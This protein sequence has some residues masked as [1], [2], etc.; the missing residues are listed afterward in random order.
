MV[1]TESNRLITIITVRPF[2]T[3]L[4]H[5]ASVK[6]YRVIGSKKIFSHLFD[7]AIFAHEYILL[8]TVTFLH[9]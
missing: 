7:E 3:P 6:K 4:R 5:I 9:L 8:Y 2:I 1:I